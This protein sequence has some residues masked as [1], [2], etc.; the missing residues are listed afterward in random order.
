[1]KKQGSV[2]NLRKGIICREDDKVYLDFEKGYMWSVQWGMSCG[3]MD[4]LMN[5]VDLD[6]VLTPY[7]KSQ[8]K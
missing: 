2:D 6:L 7:G 1:M 8:I 3:V 5:M 4:M